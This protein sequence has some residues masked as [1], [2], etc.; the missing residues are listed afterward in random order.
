MARDDFLKTS[1]VVAAG[2]AAFYKG[3]I[4]PAANIQE[5][6]SNIQ[7]V[8]GMTNDELALMKQGVRDVA[9]DSNIAA[10]ELAKASHNLVEVGGDTN[11]VLSQLDHG[12]KLGIA[13][14]NDLAQTFDFLSAA[15]KTFGKDEQYTKEIAD[16]FA[17]TTVKTNLNLAQLAESYV[18]VGGSAVNAGLDINDVNA[19]LVVMSE[20]GLKGGAAGTSLNTM[21]RNLS[22]PTDKAAESL[23]GLNVKLYDNEGKSRDMLEIMS[24]LETKLDKMSDKKRNEALSSIFDTV[25]LKGWNMLMSE[26]IEYISE[27]SEDI[28]GASDTFD[29]MGQSA[30]MTATQMDNL[31]GDIDRVKGE[32]RYTAETIGDM[33]LPNMRD[34]ASSMGDNIRNARE[35]VEANPEAVKQTV[36]ISKKIGTFAVITTGSTYAIAGLKTEIGGIRQLFSKT[37][38][39]AGKLATGIAKLGNTGT[40]VGTSIA[41]LTAIAL[42]NQYVIK[43][44]TKEYANPLLFDN[45]GVK[46]SELTDNLEANTRLQRENAQAVIDSRERLSDIRLEIQSATEDLDFYGASLRT[47]GILT[48]EEAEAMKKPF[49]DLVEAVGEDFDVL[50]ENVFEEYK[51]VSNFADGSPD[52]EG[53]VTLRNFREQFENRIEEANMWV[54]FIIDEQIAWDGDLPDGLIKKMQDELDVLRRMDIDSNTR[55]ND[56]DYLKEDMSLIDLGENPEEGKA[57]LKRLIEYANEQRDLLKKAQRAN[58]N[59]LKDFEI[60]TQ[61][62][63]D[64]TGNKEVYESNIKLINFLRETGSDFYQNEIDDFNAQIAEIAEPLLEKFKEAQIAFEEAWGNS[65]IAP[66]AVF[67]DIITGGNFDLFKP[68]DAFKDVKTEIETL[69]RFVKASADNMP[70]IVIDAE[71]NDAAVRHWSYMRPGSGRGRVSFESAW[72]NGSHA[73]G[74]PYVPFDGYIA[75][76]HRGERVMTA[77]ENRANPPPVL[78]RAAINNNYSNTPNIVISPIYNISG[79]APENLKEILEENNKKV[80]VLVM[81]VMREQAIDKRRTALE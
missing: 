9:L 14:N 31:R 19:M 10:I 25:G 16:S 33:F 1:A 30:G 74:L 58:E 29:G 62:L 38:P 72:V 12:T 47:N 11:L 77:A 39:T 43:E 73:G 3:F 27:L 68:G 22:A 15:M 66:Y 59:N 17:Y 64:D 40:V 50:F 28:D 34:M 56:L 13:T 44:L 65:E 26:G 23:E 81:D 4:E 71:V 70:D 6:M 32:L 67:A 60:M 20:A 51:R 45:G 61:E 76:L 42:A 21:L 2:G 79:N 69:E 49:K 52:I 41:A 75:E 46:L 53:M 36:D 55:S 80:T 78:S 18:N 24:D 35:W 48:P 63:Y 8:T 57:E 5:E 54:N 37:T 7:S